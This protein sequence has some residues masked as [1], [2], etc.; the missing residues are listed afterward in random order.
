LL[1]FPY[2]G[3]SSLLLSYYWNRF[4]A[5]VKPASQSASVLLSEAGVWFSDFL[6]HILGGEIAADYI[7]ILS[8]YFLVIY[9]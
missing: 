2:D 6:S 1:P 5:F 3:I 4:H 8:L 7:L 9:Y